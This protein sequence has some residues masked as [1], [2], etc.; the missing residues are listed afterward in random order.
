MLQNCLA[1]FL[2][3]LINLI[4]WAFHLKLL[5]WHLFSWDCELA[6]VSRLKKK[7]VLKGVLCWITVQISVKVLFELTE[8]KPSFSLSLNCRERAACWAQDSL[9]GTDLGG[10]RSSL[11]NSSCLVQ[12]RNAA[13]R[14]GAVPVLGTSRWR[15]DTEGGD[16]WAWWDGLG[17]RLRGLFPAQWFCGSC[18][19]AGLPGR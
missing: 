2:S 12:V 13:Q 7:P 10:V 18:R 17:I 9:R 6:L 4:F 8:M 16:Q 14:S 11:Q 19:D 1:W 3:T 15:C 5:F